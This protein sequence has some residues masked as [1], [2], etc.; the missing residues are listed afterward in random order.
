MKTQAK[1]LSTGFGLA[2]AAMLSMGTAYATPMPF[3]G[4]MIDLG[5]EACIAATCADLAAGGYDVEGGVVLDESTF[6]VA[7]KPGEDTS[8]DG[9]VTT[10]NVTSSQDNP[11]GAIAPIRVSNLNNAFGFYWG[12]IDSY[13]EVDF[14][15]GESLVHTFTGSDLAGLLGSVNEPNYGIDQYVTFSIGD[16]PNTLAESSAFDSVVLSSKGGVAFEVATAVP[17]PAPLAL[18]GMG[19]LGMGLAARRRNKS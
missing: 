19:L 16:G 1:V 11:E 15:F 18:L 3:N 2:T 17:A 10:F 8:N 14:F 9:A 12:S 6:N 4:L 5:G 7:K 13:N